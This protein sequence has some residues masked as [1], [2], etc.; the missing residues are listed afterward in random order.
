MKNIIKFGKL[1]TVEEE[2]IEL[3][4][5]EV[6]SKWQNSVNGNNGPYNDDCNLANSGCHALTIMQ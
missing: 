4:N 2:V 6:F 1:G 5:V 3:E